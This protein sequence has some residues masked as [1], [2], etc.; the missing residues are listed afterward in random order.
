[1]FK[2][3][4][5]IWIFPRYV[6]S[7]LCKLQFLLVMLMFAWPN[8]KNSI[9]CIIILY[10]YIKLNLKIYVKESVQRMEISCF[11]VLKK[12]FEYPIFVLYIWQEK[13]QCHEKNQVFFVHVLKQTPATQSTDKNMILFD[14]RSDK[15]ETT[16]TSYNK[17]FLVTMP[18]FL[19]L[20]SLFLVI[21][22]HFFSWYWSLCFGSCMRH[23][24]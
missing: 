7:C 11:K 6:S 3:Y 5:F 24:S 17:T 10:Y 14:T 9:L 13:G 16:K 12:D 20:L 23:I 15:Y 22:C 19:V 21:P 18:F 1:M 4:A 8:V 2:N